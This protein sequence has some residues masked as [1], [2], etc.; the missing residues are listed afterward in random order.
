ME[1]IIL[2][3][4]LFWSVVCQAQ[5]PNNN[6]FYQSV[7]L[8]CPASTIVPCIFGG[9][10]VTLNVVTGNTYTFSTCGGLWDTEI[11]LYNGGIIGYN[12]DFCLLQSQIVWTATFTGTINILV[13]QYP[14]TSNFSCIDLSISCCGNSNF[15]PQDCLGAITIC[16]NTAFS[17]NSVNIGCIVD[18][19]AGNY[20]CLASAERQGTWYVFNPSIAGTLA[21]SINPANPLD[22]YDFA[23]W[24]PFPTGI[25]IPQMCPPIGPPLRCSYAAPSGTTGLDFT[26]TDFSEGAA[27]DKWVRYLTVA[28]NE[29]YLMYISNWSQSGLAFNL[30]WNPSNTASLNCTT[31]PIEIISFNGV[32]RGDF[33]YLYWTSEINQ[34][35]L[36]RSQ[37]LV[38]W[39]L[40]TETSEF[41][42][43][44]KT[45]QQGINY[46][47]LNYNKVVAI[48]NIP[49]E[50]IKTTN[51]LGQEV[52][53]DYKG[54]VIEYY[55]MGQPIRIFR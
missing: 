4:A 55:R 26:S 36:E 25:S 2:I 28:T 47:R 14:C 15:P 23:I 17:N 31:L 19:N 38:N 53:L 29:V 32:K 3:L 52:G 51:L 9:E 7:N 8:T 49:R 43:I 5:C 50:P 1:R 35:L 13:D 11:T 16:T 42:Y 10:Y 45:F 6:I 37:D 41:N 34:F 18:L 12:D 39:E 33:N 27:G 24:G 54:I 22:D 44:D 30:N 48:D 46:Y 40:L 20:G 21:F